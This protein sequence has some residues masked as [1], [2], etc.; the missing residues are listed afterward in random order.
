MAGSSSILFLLSFAMFALGPPR[1]PKSVS[2]F[3]FLLLL[4][5]RRSG[6]GFQLN[7]A[8]RFGWGQMDP[9]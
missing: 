8:I 5:R 4:A 9:A 6:H 1:P 3:L 2:S 7:S